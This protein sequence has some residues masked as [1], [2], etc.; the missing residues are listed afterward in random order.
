[1]ELNIGL[2]LARMHDGTNMP[3]GYV[4][5]KTPSKLEAVVFKKM[6]MSYA[7]ML[8]EAIAEHPELVLE[9]EAEILKGQVNTLFGPV[10]TSIMESMIPKL[11]NIDPNRVIVKPIPVDETNRDND[12]DQNLMKSIDAVHAAQHA[13][14]DAKQLAK[15]F[16]KGV[17]YLV[18]AMQ[19]PG[20]VRIQAMMIA[21]AVMSRLTAAVE[22]TVSINDDDDTKGDGPSLRH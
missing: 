4:L 11:E 15:D 5:I 9:G 21:A 13:T 19:S 16:I 7:K 10:E 18:T 14:Q 12:H 2:Q 20:P 8:D 17:D 22:E 6:L 1:M 3:L